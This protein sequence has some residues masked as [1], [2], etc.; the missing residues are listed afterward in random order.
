M[1]DLSIGKTWPPETQ[2]YQDRRTGVTV[3]QL[4][5][6]RGHSHH[7]YFTNSGWYADGHKL[8]FASDR[9]NKTNL[10]SIDLD[11]FAIRQLTDLAPLPLPREVEFLR[12]CLNPVKAEAYF[13]YG[14]DLLALDLDTLATRTLYRM[15]DGFDVSMINCS[16]DGKH[17]YA[18]ISEDMSDR[19]QVDL[20]RGYV[21]FRETWAAHP[22]SRI[23]QIAVDGSQHA[24]I[25]EEAYWLGHVNTSPT[26]RHLI[27]FCHEG[28][29]D[30]VDQRIWGMDV[31]KGDVWKIRPCDEDEVVGHEYW[32]ADGETIGYHGRKDDGSKFLGHIRYDN[33]EQV[34]NAFPGETGHIH[35]NDSSLIV[36]DGGNVVRLWRWDGDRYDGPRVLCEHNSSMKIQQLHVH[37]RFSPDGAYV[38]FTSDVTGYGNVYQVEV[39]GFGR[40]P[41]VDDA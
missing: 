36:G 23:E 31:D 6:Y 10:F 15:P 30:K 4:T 37:P 26:Q 13:W 17:V 40:L 28:P 2:V 7:F 34:E 11:T 29:W 20:L 41:R 32:Y 27:T 3:R 25:W 8:L 16:A 33:S 35:S 38:L 22:L 21:G 12:A 24:T 9:D 14:L 39:P 5:N 18:S 19:F 1:P